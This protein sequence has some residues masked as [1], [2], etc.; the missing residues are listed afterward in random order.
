MIENWIPSHLLLRNMEVCMG[1]AEAVFSDKR[2]GLL[3]VPRC[4][5]TVEVWK[6]MRY[7]R[8]HAEIPERQNE[9]DTLREHVVK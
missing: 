2:I 7:R 5:Q 3:G 9:V 1:L 8:R 4:I 6:I